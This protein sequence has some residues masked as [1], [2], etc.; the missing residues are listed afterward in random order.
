MLCRPT[1]NVRRRPQ[2]GLSGSVAQTSVWP[3]SNYGHLGSASE[4]GWSV[5]L[6]VQWRILN[7]GV[8]RNEL[9][10][11]ESKRREAEDELTTR[12]DETTREVWIAYI[13]CD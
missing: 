11:A 1:L 12:E 2:I 10:I 7:G 4:P 13:G 6:G 3:T 8:R 5:A 9:S